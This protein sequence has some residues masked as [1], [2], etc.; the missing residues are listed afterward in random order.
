MSRVVKI[1]S[2]LAAGGLFCFVQLA[3]VEQANA[4]TPLRNICRVKG[5]EENVLRGLGLVVGLSGTGEVNDP[6]TMRALARSMEIMGNPVSQRGLPGEESFDEL[7]KIKNAALVWVTASVPGTGARRGD[8]LNCKVSAINGK[9]LKGGS[10]A[11]AALQGPNVND[12]RVYALAEGLIHLDS[13]DQPLVGSIHGGCQMEED[14]YTPF[15]QEGYVTLVLEKNHADFQT[16][17]EIVDIIHQTHFKEDED[18]QD[19]RAVNAANIVVKIPESYREDPV[20]FVSNLLELQ[21][22]QPEPEAR[23]VINERT[24]SIVISG[25]V[26]IG[27]VVVSH[28]NIVVEANETG[29]P[30]ADVTLEEGGA[31]KLQ[32]LVDALNALNVPNTDAIDIIK[33]IERNGKL[34]GRLIID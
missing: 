13:P 16:A 9:S 1:I 20:G 23:V 14:V 19:V 17:A 27:D 32:S 28:R 4:R 3:H 18:R 31:A 24:G 22:Y 34:H 7:K 12:N 21:V 8:K 30:F 15:V 11:F 10:L 26:Q 6:A 25:N 33:S 5:Q 29:T 2:V